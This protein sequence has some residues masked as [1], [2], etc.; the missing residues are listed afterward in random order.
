MS[1]LTLTLIQGPLVAEW[2]KR[3]RMDQ[4]TDPK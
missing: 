1:A 4:W 3:R 2:T